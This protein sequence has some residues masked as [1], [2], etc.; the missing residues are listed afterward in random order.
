MN[1]MKKRSTDWLGWRNEDVRGRKVFRMV[2]TK[3]YGSIND[4]Y[5]VLRSMDVHMVRNR[6]MEIIYI[7]LIL[8][9]AVWLWKPRKE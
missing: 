1:R 6:Y 8:I 5:G 7:L 3:L 9:I 4:R 2:R